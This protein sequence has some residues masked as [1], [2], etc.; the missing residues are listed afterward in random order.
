MSEPY[1]SQLSMD[2]S[3]RTLVELRLDPFGA[4]ALPSKEPRPD[5]HA[6]RNH[7]TG[8]QGFV[9]RAR[10]LAPSRMADRAP[11]PPTVEIHGDPVDGRRRGALIGLRFD[12]SPVTGFA[13]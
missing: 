11:P 6:C 2:V 3:W 8:D 5:D 1:R 13:R 7:E 12:V 10:S 4:G 9:E